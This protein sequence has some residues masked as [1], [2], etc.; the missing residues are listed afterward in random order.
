MLDGRMFKAN[1]GNSLKMIK[2]D[3]NGTLCTN[4]NLGKEYIYK[5]E[6][7][8]KKSFWF[9]RNTLIDKPVLHISRLGCVG[10]DWLL[11]QQ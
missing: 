10:S 4:A 1:F 11:Y 8:L 2:E 3:F 9:S 7:F 5:Y 6:S